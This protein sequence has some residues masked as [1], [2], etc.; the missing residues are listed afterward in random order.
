MDALLVLFRILFYKYL[1]TVS[2]VQYCNKCSVI[3]YI[4]TKEGVVAKCYSCLFSVYKA[5]EGIL[6]TV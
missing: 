6:S 1:K 2:E 5:G 3:F 4:T